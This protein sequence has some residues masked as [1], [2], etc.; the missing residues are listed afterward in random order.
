M[1]ENRSRTLIIA[2]GIVSMLIVIATGITLFGFYLDDLEEKEERERIFREYYSQK[3]SLYKAENELY[4]D[5][6]VDVA[7]LGDS[8]TDG[9]DLSRYYPEF[10]TA[11]RGIGGDTTIGLED[12]M[13]VS[14]YDLKPKVAVIL[15]GGNNLN[16]M[17]DN[18][19]DIIVGIEE[20][21]PETEIVICSLTS[22]GMDWGHKNQIAAY[23]NVFLKKLAMKHDCAF[24]DLY[25]PL[26][27]ENT[28]EIHAEYTT[29]GA[30]LTHEGYLVLTGAVKEKL[31]ELI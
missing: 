4:D 29:D 5:F 23:N 22:M 26:F 8:L 12:R 19:E 6:E 11:N 13:G 2:V 30:H 20:N 10:I 28:G 3:L 18:Y 7:F 16:T 1:M 24:V 17:L 27:D 14:L 21:C 31:S 25:T 15:I 9:C